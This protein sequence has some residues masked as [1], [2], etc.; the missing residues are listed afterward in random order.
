MTSVVSG[1]KQIDSGEQGYFMPLSSLQGIIY[2]FT[3]G[4]G[5]GGSYLQGS[6]SVASW[7]T[8]F[9]NGKGNPYLSSINGANKGL[10]RDMGKTVVSSARTF[11]KV[12]L[13][14]PQ[15]GT[16]STGGVEGQNAAGATPVQDYLTGY[17]EMGFLGAGTPAP[18]AKYGM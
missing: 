9:Y 2:A 6:F 11:R 3:P 10:L 15:V 16:V 7:A 8:N 4:S 1:P 18:V 13:L 14:M 5:S 17:I 12:Q